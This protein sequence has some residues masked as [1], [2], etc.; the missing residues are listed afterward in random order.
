MRDV[1]EKRDDERCREGLPKIKLKKE[2]GESS[3]DG[4]FR[5]FAFDLG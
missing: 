4:Q 3:D 5:P 2:E 1:R